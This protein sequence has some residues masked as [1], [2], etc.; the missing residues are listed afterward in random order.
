MKHILLIE[1]DIELATL[2]RS[3]LS[4]HN[5]RI[6]HLNS[7]YGLESITLNTI[8]LILCDINLPGKDGFRVLSELKQYYQRPVVMLTA[9]GDD[10]DH[11]KGLQFGAEDYL[12]KPIA[13]QLLLAKLNNI[14]K[15]QVTTIDEHI[16]NIKLDR[17]LG[18]VR[19]GEQSLSLTPSEFHLFAIFY[20]HLEQLITRDELFTYC[21]GRE[22]DGLAR[23]IDGR[24]VRLRKKLESLSSEVLQ[25]KT[26]WGKGYL[27]T[28]AN[29]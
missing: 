26:V 28:H 19:V 10:K 22:Y 13:P 7:A 15:Q 24:I 25:L 20:Q 16:P 29:H 2:I 17:S 18:E 11:I 14:L 21:V 4:K 12:I 5:F 27:L 3:Y 8:D 1:D 23:T 9:R 6:L